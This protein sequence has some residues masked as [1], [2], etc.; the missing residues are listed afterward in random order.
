VRPSPRV[1]V[2]GFVEKIGATLHPISVLKKR[3][4]N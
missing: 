3:G 2:T 4:K 1:S